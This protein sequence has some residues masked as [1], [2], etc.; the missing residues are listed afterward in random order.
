[1]P[2]IFLYRQVSPMKIY[3]DEVIDGHITHTDEYDIPDN[4]MLWKL[5]KG[6]MQSKMKNYYTMEEVKKRIHD[7]YGF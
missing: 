1:M 6:E 7:K 2:F 5:I 4:R 3:R